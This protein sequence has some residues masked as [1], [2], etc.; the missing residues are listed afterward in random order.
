MNGRMA[1][2]K[3]TTL[4]GSSTAST[5]T[6]EQANGAT[7][8]GTSTSVAVT[9]QNGVEDRANLRTNVTKDI[10]NETESTA[11]VRNFSRVG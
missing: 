10:G 11:L 5:Q 9:T 3:S 8:V 2:S 4:E 6:S 7:G 1:A